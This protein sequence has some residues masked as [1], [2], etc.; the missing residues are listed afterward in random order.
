MA[1]GGLPTSRYQKLNRPVRSGAT[2]PERAARVNREPWSWR[3]STRLA[4]PRETW[5]YDGRGHSEVSGEMMRRRV[6][7]ARRS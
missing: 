4:Y 2:S 1:E 3:R 6:Q 7:A 5:A